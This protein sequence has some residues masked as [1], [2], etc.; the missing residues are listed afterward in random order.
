MPGGAAASTRMT[1]AARGRGGVPAASTGRRVRH[2]T[3]PKRR[4]ANAKLYGR[5]KSPPDKE[6]MKEQAAAEMRAALL[7]EPRSPR[8]LGV[9]PPAPEKSTDGLFRMEDDS[10]SS[11]NWAL[12]WVE[13][14]TEAARSRTSFFSR[15][16]K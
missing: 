9:A 13:D 1:V 10:S 2:S 4:R 3:S 15:R 5:S 14:A 11:S 8:R 12:G 16:G 7:T 6:T